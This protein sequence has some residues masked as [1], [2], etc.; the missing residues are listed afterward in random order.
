MEFKERFEELLFENK[1]N[2]KDLSNLIE[3]GKSSL[4]EY[5]DQTIPNIENAVK[6]ANFFDCT[7]NFLFCL[8]ENPKSYKFD[9]T[10]DIN[11]F[12][13]RYKQLLK[14]NKLTHHKLCNDTG[15][16]KSSHRLW[17]NGSPPKL[18]AL[19]KIADYLNCSI[20]YLV[21]RSNSKF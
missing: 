14:E 11:L 12:Y 17:K 10:Y 19:V 2:A 21:G 4:Y 1:M 7:L 5:L 9:K 16:N 15:V 3:V 18:E 8:E 13:T 6:L 20:D